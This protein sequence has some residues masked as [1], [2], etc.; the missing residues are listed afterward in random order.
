MGFPKKPVKSLSHAVQLAH[1]EQC[2][3]RL[4]L[5]AEQLA[6]KFEIVNSGYRIVINNGRDSDQMIQHLH[7][8][9]LGGQ[10][11][12]WPPWPVSKQDLIDKEAVDVDYVD[13]PDDHGIP[14]GGVSNTN[15]VLLRLEE[16]EDKYILLDHDDSDSSFPIEDTHSMTQS[17]SSP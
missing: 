2:L 7:V 12:G 1:S 9:V 4:M 11:M 3:G 16:D 17:I 14:A 8:H 6:R 13:I 15:P 10:S 5:V